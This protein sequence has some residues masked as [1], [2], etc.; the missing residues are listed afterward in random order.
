MK[1]IKARLSKFSTVDEY[2]SGWGVYYF[3]GG[4]LLPTRNAEP[5][6][7][8]VS[9]HIQIASGD[10]VLRGEGLVEEVRTNS[11]GDPVGMVIR[12]SKLDAASKELMHRILNHKKETR[13]SA[14]A[15]VE[16][17]GSHQ[18]LTDQT[19]GEHLA[20]SEIGAIADALE[21]TFSSIFSGSF[22]SVGG[23]E[24]EAGDTSGLGGF[25]STP[26]ADVFKGS[27]EEHP[28]DES[29]SAVNEDDPSTDL[30]E[31]ATS[32]ASSATPVP[33][34]DA[35]AIGMP[36]FSEGPTVDAVNSALERLEVAAPET[37]EPKLAVTEPEAAA[38]SDG[39]EPADV[40]AVAKDEPDT[41][42]TDA[43]TDEAP[44]PETAPVVASADEREPARTTSF[45]DAAAKAAAA[46]A[47]G[48]AAFDDLLASTTLSAQ[49]DLPS[50][51]DAGLPVLAPKPKGLFGKLIAWLK[52]LFGG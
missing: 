41:A 20:A 28:E 18:G 51:P 10:T 34:A 29:V 17:T 43:V 24:S 40:P 25:V 36:S 32:D 26:V 42:A 27:G 14:N 13:T 23:V 44:E 5:V 7:S 35:T 33:A 9:L 16:D 2:I 6:G 21:E 45:A 52:G 50:M 49:P 46:K 31:E 47:E 38:E 1:A 3:S 12:F 15:S 48:E 22:T 19:T 11:S 37:P 39:I 4:L 8:A 30:E